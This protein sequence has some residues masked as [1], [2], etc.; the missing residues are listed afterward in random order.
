LVERGHSRIA[1][2][3][4]PDDLL[5]S[6]DRL[7]AYRSAMQRYGYKIHTDYVITGCWNEVD[8]Q[9]SAEK[10][11]QLSERPTAIVASSDVI[12]FGVL[13]ALNT[14]NLVPG[15]DVAVVGFDDV[16]MAAHSNPP[17]TTVQQPIYDIGVELVD[18]LIMFM[19]GQSVP[20]RCIEPKLIVRQSA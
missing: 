10:L 8:G 20:S 13:R 7:G 3:G 11:L 15:K 17:L 1:F 12:A 18:M 9:V 19:T 2:I 14:F 6:R 16:P 4:L 5:V